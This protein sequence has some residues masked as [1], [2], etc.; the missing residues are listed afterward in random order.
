MAIADVH[1]D[2]D[3]HSEQSASHPVG[4]PVWLGIGAAAGVIGLLPWIITGM[5]LP[6]Q[7]LWGSNTMPAD[8]PIAL[9]PL[10]QYTTVTVAAY[11]VAGSVVAGIVSRAG[12]VR[13]NRRGFLA[14]TG[15]ILLL[16]LIAIVQSLVVVGSGLRPGRESVIYFAALIVVAT[17]AF[18]LGVLALLLIARAPRAG[19]LIGLGIGALALSWWAEALIAAPFG[20]VTPTQSAL[21]NLMR[22]LP[23]ILC[24]I[25]I[26]WAGISSAGRI[27]A[28]VVSLVGVTIVPVLVT[29]FVSATGSRVLLPYPS[30]MLEYGI[31]VFQAAIRQVEVTT[32][33]PIIIVVVAAAGLALQ[34]MLRRRRL[35]QTALVAPAEP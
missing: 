2:L 25:A 17:I 22:F 28:A 10:S 21:L 11:I 14:L 3:T 30:E 6:L 31:Q 33:P 23:A 18:A 12:G 9:L 13:Q 26:A 24:G 16:Q 8:M 1:D 20:L 4:A 19:A 32:V 29:A 15:G 35:R 34:A 7:N 5:R 27:I